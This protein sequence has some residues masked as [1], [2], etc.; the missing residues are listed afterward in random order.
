VE[1]RPKKLPDDRIYALD[2]V[3]LIYFLERHAD[4]Y[5]R[6]KGLFLRI[7]AG[8]ISAIISSLVF[9]ELLVPAYCVGKQQQAGKIIRILSNFP[10]LTVISLTTE[11]SAAAAR[12]RAVHG[13]RT[14]D[15]IHAA[16]ALESDAAGF[17]TNDKSFL[18]LVTGDFGVWLFGD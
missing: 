16:T 14:P 2:T 4:F 17:I 6:A 1:L 18:K 7:E 10:N 8:E 12:L 3:T 11:I 13:L 9:A 15:A 5:P